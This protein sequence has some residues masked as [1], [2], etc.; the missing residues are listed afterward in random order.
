MQLNKHIRE[1]HSYIFEAL[2]IGAKIQK[3]PKCQSTD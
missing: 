2:F 1:L 3:Q